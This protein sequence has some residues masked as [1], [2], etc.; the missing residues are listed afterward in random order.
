MH[1]IIKFTHIAVTAM[2]L[3]TTTVVT[4]SAFPGEAGASCQPWATG[5][6]ARNAREDTAW[7]ATCDDDGQ[8]FG[9]H[10][11]NAPGNGK[12]IYIEHDIGPW[13]AANAK[14]WNCKDS[15]WIRYNYFERDGE[16]RFRMCEFKGEGCS[17]WKKSHGY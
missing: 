16:N 4:I 9:K 11:D 15:V 12:C 7:D 17:G 8:Y 6:W 3:I 14:F 5:H 13:W 1:S 2:A 10:M